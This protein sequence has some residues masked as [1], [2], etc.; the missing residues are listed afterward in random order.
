MQHILY[1]AHDDLE[2]VGDQIGPAIYGH[3]I[4]VLGL[5]ESE[6]LYPGSHVDAHI[7]IGNGD[8]AY[9]VFRS[10]IIVSTGTDANGSPIPAVHGIKF[11]G[12]NWD[13]G[14]CYLDPQMKTPEEF[15]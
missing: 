12:Q 5:E 13:T 6:L 2:E 8:L 3:E 11:F 7:R 9:A 10:K 1:S 15:A 4:R 14:G